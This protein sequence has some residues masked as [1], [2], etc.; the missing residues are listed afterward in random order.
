MRLGHNFFMVILLSAHAPLA[1]L[2][3]L[4]DAFSMLLLRNF[5]PGFASTTTDLGR[6]NDMARHH[7][8]M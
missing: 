7:G 4:P 3:A 1:S 8:H 5:V 2:S 6:R